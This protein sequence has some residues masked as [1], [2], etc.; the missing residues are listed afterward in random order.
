MNEIYAK[1]IKL[2]EFECIYRPL[3][4]EYPLSS[5]EFYSEYLISRDY[6][7]DVLPVHKENRLWTVFEYEDSYAI[8]NTVSNVHSKEFIGYL[9]TECP[10]ERLYANLLEVVVNKE[11]KEHKDV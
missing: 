1:E 3:H 4:T 8:R 6:Y 7:S 2:E 10:Y 11:N 5:S 9:I